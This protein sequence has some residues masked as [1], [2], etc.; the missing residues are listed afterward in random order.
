MTDIFKRHTLSL[1]ITLFTGIYLLALIFN[2]TPYL[3]GFA[4]YPQW[5]WEY[6]IPAIKLPLLFPLLL[7]II[8]VLFAT[9]KLLS[10][11]DTFIKNHEKKILS[12]IF[13]LCV[14]FYLFVLAVSSSGIF[15]PIQRTI[16]PILNGYFA[17]SLTIDTLP[18][19]LNNYHNTVS[20]Y[21]NLA[22]FHLP[23]SILLYWGINQVSSIPLFFMQ[24]PETFQPSQTDLLPYWNILLPNE[25]IGSV[26][27]G[28]L[29]LAICAGTSITLYYLGKLLY[30]PKVGLQAAILYIF[31]P[32]IIFFTPY[33]DVYFPLFSALSLYF[34]IKGFK[35]QNITSFFFSGLLLFIG[36]F[37]V[38]TILMI[39]II[40]MV[41]GINYVLKKQLTLKR[42][43]LFATIF[44][45]G[46]LLLPIALYF[47][48]GFN[49]IAT[50]MT[51]LRDHASFVALRQNI[52][53]WYVYNYY[54]FFMFFGIPLLIVFILQLKTL[55]LWV[56]NRKNH[57]DI[58]FLG[59]C[60]MTLLIDISGSMNGET[61]RTWMVFIPLILLPLVK[62]IT[63]MK[64]NAYLTILFLQGIQVI[65][66]IATLVTAS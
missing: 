28:Y 25:K 46:F 38:L 11:S 22:A 62:F 31:I 32:G 50:T 43:S 8:G 33:S 1:F 35:T 27:S 44:S 26:L 5:M 40:Y 52:P 49:T 4:P 21:L 58:L 17:A 18:S 41:I 47:M 23:G 2:V 16:H 65:T 13:L 37:F 64:K 29:I 24:F 60:L 48:Y 56:R 19:F 55:F 51:I 63:S 42:L 20:G 14:L 39:T 10:K 15:I 57:I 6:Q 34:F 36:A 59:F 7:L 3:R 66:M 61:G 53:L 30:S 45:I 12:G 9:K 54:D